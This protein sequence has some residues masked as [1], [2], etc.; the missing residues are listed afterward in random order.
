VKDYNAI[1]LVGHPHL[2]YSGKNKLV[3]ACTSLSAAQAVMR[4]MKVKPPEPTHWGIR[5]YGN[6]SN[7]CASV[8]GVGNLFAYSERELT[9]E[10]CKSIL[11]T[12]RANAKAKQERDI[13][14]RKRPAVIDRLSQWEELE[15]EEDLYGKI[16]C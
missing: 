3:G 6:W 9:C 10:T 12:A 16:R 5:M 14:I 8:N 13:A 15:R 1:S 7:V 4:L 2:I 11:A